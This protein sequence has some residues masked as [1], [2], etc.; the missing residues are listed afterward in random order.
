MGVVGVMFMESSLEGKE[1]MERWAR[2]GTA[3]GAMTLSRNKPII[4]IVSTY[5]NDIQFLLLFVRLIRGG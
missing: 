1:A 3:P 2:P 5:V 4:S